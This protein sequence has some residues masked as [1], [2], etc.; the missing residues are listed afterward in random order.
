M[1]LCK[2]CGMPIDK[3]PDLK[4]EEGRV[5]VRMPYHHLVGRIRICK[6]SKPL[7]SAY[8]MSVEDQID[9]LLTKYERV[10]EMQMV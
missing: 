4:N 5:V 3:Y 6:G 7:T 9:R 10:E 8:P 2:Y 1:K